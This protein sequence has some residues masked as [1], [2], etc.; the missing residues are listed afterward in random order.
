MSRS[1][2]AARGHLPH[3]VVGVDGDG[4]L[5]RLGRLV[6]EMLVHR[7]EVARDE[8]VAV[9]IGLNGHGCGPFARPHGNKYM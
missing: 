8:V 6:V 2:Q 3:D 5:D 9:G 7:G 1:N 4:R